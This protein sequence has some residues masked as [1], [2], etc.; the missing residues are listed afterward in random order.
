[1]PH[2]RPLSRRERGHAAWVVTHLAN[3]QQAAA[4]LIAGS[5]FGGDIGK[6][7]MLHQIALLTAFATT[8]MEGRSA[9]R[10]RP[11]RRTGDW[12][13]GT[14]TI[15]VSMHGRSDATAMR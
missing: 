7:S 12:D 5:C 6:S 13:F 9:L 4:A 3:I 14:S 1:M 10:R 15:A 2:P 11:W 8:A